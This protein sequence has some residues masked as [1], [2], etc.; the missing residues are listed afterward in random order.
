MRRSSLAVIGT[1]ALLAMSALSAPALAG[2]ASRS[3]ALRIQLYGART[4]TGDYVFKAI[5][6]RDGTG[7]AITRVT[8]ASSTFPVTGT[9]VTRIYFADG[10]SKHRDSFRQSA[11]NAQGISKFTGS[12]RCAGGTGIH[13]REKCHYTF[14]GTYNNKT[15]QNDLKITGTDTR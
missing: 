8:S 3:R 14:T 4:S 13:K 15:D 1:L 2:H 6:S 9:S 5:S 11:P 10:V 12:G 7:A